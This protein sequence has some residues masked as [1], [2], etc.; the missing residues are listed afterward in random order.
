MIV[1]VNLNRSC[2]RSNKASSSAAGRCGPVT[3]QSDEIDLRHRA[4]ARCLDPDGARTDQLQRVDIDRLHVPRRTRCRHRGSPPPAAP[5]QQLRCDAAR[6][7]P[8]P[9]SPP[10]EAGTFGALGVNK[11]AVSQQ[12]PL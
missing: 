3:L 1:V 8:P 11:P 5:R 9:Q 6:G 7:A 4:Q 12:L 2:T 10:E